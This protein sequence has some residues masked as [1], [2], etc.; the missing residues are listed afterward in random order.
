MAAGLRRPRDDEPI[1]LT[2]SD[3]GVAM[4]A[5]GQHR[6]AAVVIANIPV[7]LLARFSAQ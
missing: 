4:V 7:K 6:L 5:D 2:V 3:N 1:E